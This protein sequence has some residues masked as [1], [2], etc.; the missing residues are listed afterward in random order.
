MIASDVLCQ[1]AEEYAQALTCY[2]KGFWCQRLTQ[3]EYDRVLKMY[4]VNDKYNNE[5]FIGSE[6]YAADCICWIKQLLG[7]G[8]VGHRLSYKE[9]TSN[10]LGDC[11][12]QRFKASLTDCIASVEPPAGY[13]LATDTH[14]A[15]S[16]GG[17]VWIDC[18]FDA[19][20]NGIAIHTGGVPR[21]FTAGKIPGV[22]Y[23]EPEQTEREI[24][25]KFTN[26][27]IDSYLTH[28]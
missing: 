25:R 16:L 4:P 24:L 6:V 5:R 2:L 11:T 28:K 3:A 19:N 10:P 17:G 15:L 8:S 13:G 27:L 1:R 20:Q 18:N 12:T 22:L 23:E 7:G 26:W 9:M 14:A 21:Q